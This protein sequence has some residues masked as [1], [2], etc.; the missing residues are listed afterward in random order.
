MNLLGLELIGAVLKSGDFEELLTVGI[1]GE[2]FTEMERPAFTTI[3]EHHRKHGVLPKRR[4]LEALLTPELVEEIPQ[5]PPEPLSFY[6]ERVVSRA[7]GTLLTHYTQKALKSLQSGNPDDASEVLQKATSEAQKLGVRGSRVV[8]LT[9]EYERRW[10]DYLH[11]RGLARSGIGYDGLPTPW[12]TMNKMTMGLQD[13]SFTVLAGRIYA[14][15][16]WTLLAMLQHVWEVEKKSPLLSSMEMAARL[17]G[18]RL[19]TLWSGVPH[20]E[21]IRGELDTPDEDLHLKVIDGYKD[22]P[23]IFCASPPLVR[24]TDDLKA[25]I[26]EYRPDGGV[27]VDGINRMRGGGETDRYRRVAEAADEL[28]FAAEDCHVPVVG[29]THFNREGGKTTRT[30]TKGDLEDI[31]YSLAI[32]EQVDNAFAVMQNEDLRANSMALIKRMKVREEADNTPGVL[33]SFNHNRMDFSEIGPWNGDEVD[34]GEG[35]FGDESVP[36]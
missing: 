19:D 7:R 29:T 8:D 16:T 2:M 13:G 36:F 20:S 4:T 31:G 23:P 32:P 28:K 15:K 1:S 14:G 18:R 25:L 11:R 33:I 21:F 17:L 5:D 26:R 34:S 30:S 27:W 22:M 24:T 6:V 9:A 35:G 3:L 10:A 12:P